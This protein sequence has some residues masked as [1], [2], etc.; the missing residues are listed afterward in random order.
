MTLGNIKEISEWLEAI[1]F[2]KKEQ[3]AHISLSAAAFAPSFRKL[4]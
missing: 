2:L 1:G 4:Q 3:I